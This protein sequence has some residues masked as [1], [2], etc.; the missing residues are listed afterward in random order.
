MES[1][2]ANEIKPTG[3]NKTI[4]QKKEEVLRHLQQ[5]Y[6]II[7]IACKR[8]GVGRTMFYEYLKDPVFKEKVAKITE[9]YVSYAETRL[10]DLVRT[11][12]RAA[13][14]FYLKAKAKDRGY[15]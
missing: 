3:K 14:I 11:G 6:G 13:I 4:T 1:N 8:A 2:I 10:M 12:D 15:Y 5:C 7:T 9:S